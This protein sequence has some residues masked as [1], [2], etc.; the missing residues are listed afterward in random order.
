V[1]RFLE[2]AP[3]VVLVNSK[4]SSGAEALAFVLRRER[5][6][7]TLGERT[8]GRT[9]VRQVRELPD[10]STVQLTIGRL[11]SPIGRN[12]SIDGVEIDHVVPDL[13]GYEYGQLPA[14]K[15]LLAAITMLREKK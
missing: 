13:A 7:Q 6:A 10:G 5:Q 15:P 9:E 1:A 3:V 14:D 2:Q 8:L 11:L 4:T 12:W